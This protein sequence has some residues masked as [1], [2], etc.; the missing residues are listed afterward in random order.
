MADLITAM[1]AAFTSIQA[2]IIDVFE[3]AVPATLVVIGIGLAITLG[4]KYF[5]K[6]TRGS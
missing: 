3:V 4:I 1:G 5:K 6:L 2:D